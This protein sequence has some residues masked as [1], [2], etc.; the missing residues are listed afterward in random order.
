MRR[1]IVLLAVIVV[2]CH[3]VD[4]RQRYQGS[5]ETQALEHGLWP[6]SFIMPP[7]QEEPDEKE[8]G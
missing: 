6:D 1:Y 2:G 7:E 4:V 3:R 8:T 5:E